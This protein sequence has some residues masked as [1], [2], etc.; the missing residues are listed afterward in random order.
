M[1]NSTY[2]DVRYFMAGL[3]VANTPKIFETDYSAYG[4]D[5]SNTETVAE[6]GDNGDQQS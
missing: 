1:K 3:Q 2:D 4:L 5:D 6:G